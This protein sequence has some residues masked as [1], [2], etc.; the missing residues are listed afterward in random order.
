MYIN[1]YTHTYIC[2]YI[3]TNLH[4]YVHHGMYVKDKQTSIHEN[5]REEQHY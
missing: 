2:M 1:T 4:T 3:N 5:R